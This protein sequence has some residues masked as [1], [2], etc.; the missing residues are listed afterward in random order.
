MSVTLDGYTLQRA[1][2]LRQKSGPYGEAPSEVILDWAECR[3][4]ES[5]EVTWDKSIGGEITIG[6]GQAWFD[7]DIAGVRRGDKLLLEEERKFTIVR[8]T[9]NRDLDGPVDHTKLV[10]G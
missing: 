10:L 9:K 7:G 5:G 6:T 2:V 1:T 3:F 4:V 8:I